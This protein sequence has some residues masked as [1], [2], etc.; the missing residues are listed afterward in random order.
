[1][2]PT[3]IWITIP[4]RYDRGHFFFKHNLC[5]YPQFNYIK[6]R[7]VDPIWHHVRSTANAETHGQ[8]GC[9]LSHYF[10]WQIGLATGLEH[11]IFME[12]DSVILP[13]FEAAIPEICGSVHD[14]LHLDHTSSN[15][16]PGS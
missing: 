15:E 10:A 3:I 9:W 12:D 13:E 8:A 4:R 7:G 14:L 16:D 6:V 5:R 2:T 1:V 11:L